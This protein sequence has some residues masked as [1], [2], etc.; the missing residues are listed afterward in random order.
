MASAQ[1]EGWHKY[2]VF[3][4]T[5]NDVIETSNKVFYLSKGNLF[6]FS[7]EDEESYVYSPLNK[8]S[9]NGIAS[10]HYNA[11]GKYLLIAYDNCNIDVL[12]DNGKVVNLPEI[13]YAQID[14]TKGINDVAFGQGR[15]VVSMPTGIV[16]YDD[17]KMEVIESA[18]Y[19]ASVLCAAVMNDYLL[20]CLHGDDGYNVYFS[21][22]NQRHNNMDKFTRLG[23]DMLAQMVPLDGSTLMTVHKAERRLALRTIDFENGTWTR[24]MPIADFAPDSPARRFSDGVYAFDSNRIMKVSGSGEGSVQPLPAALRGQKIAVRDN[25]DK[26]WAGDSRGIARYDISNSTPTVLYDKMLAA[27]AIT[28]GKV[29]YMK[30]SPDGKRLYI[31]N[32]ETSIFK[33][34]AIAE[35]SDAYQTT[36]IIEDGFPRDASL[37]NASADHSKSIEWQA[38]NN[39]KRMYGDPAWIVE[40][41]DN[42]DIYYC[43]NNHEGVYVLKRNAQTGEYDEIGKFGL[44]NSPVPD[45]WGARVQDVNI[46][47][48][49][50]LWIGYQLGAHY[51]VLPAAKR[52]ADPATVT[53]ADWKTCAKLAG[54]ESLDQRDMMSLFCRKSNMMFLFSAKDGGGFF[55]IDTKGSYDNPADDK[56]LQW[57]QLI[58][59]DGN[60]FSVPTRITFA[61]EDNRGC[62]WIGTSAGIIEIADPTAATDHSMTVRRPKVPRNDGTNYADYLLDSDQINWMALDPSGRK[63]V[64]TQNSGLFLVSET[65]D[66]IIRNYNSENSPLLSNSICS[67]EC[68]PQSNVVYVGTSDGLFTFLSDSSPAKDD[69][70]EILAYPNPVRPEYTGDVTISGLMDNTIVKIADAAGHVVHQE[71][72]EGGMATWSA[73]APDGSRVRSGIYY[74]YA[75]SSDGTQ[76]SGAVTKILVIN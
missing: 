69:F 20:I 49:G 37:K 44:S 75:I 13:R 23:G 59:Q 35:C 58:D 26:V 4:D 29:G 22:L 70:S 76:S 56:V 9:D 36:N 19:R 71:R 74:V 30:W 1:N 62:V 51:A 16:I 34:Y 48:Q 3:A 12:Y 8:L 14:G 40:D 61:L 68:D 43:A 6:S 27:D 57:K 5:I 72:A 45:N 52:K 25:T 41:P 11:E 31:S 73:C 60:M 15:I 66:K 7:P 18:N 2:P 53:A 42:A 24:S 28:C 50:N 33:Q 67:V 38:K 39:N 54:N 17:K 32:I 55:A 63:W 10:L 21:P 47:P 65:G 64:A 46:D